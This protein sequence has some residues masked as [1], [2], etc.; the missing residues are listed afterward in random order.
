MGEVTVGKS[1]TD[2][3]YS[4]AVAIQKMMKSI[5]LVSLAVLALSSATT[6][7]IENGQVCGLNVEACSTKPVPSAGDIELIRESWP[8]IKN[9]NVLAEFVLEHFRVHPKTQE[10]L[11]ELAGIAL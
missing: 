8:V 5:I 10:L 2:T 3:E 7:S 1:D 6:I 9:K 4:S 11:P